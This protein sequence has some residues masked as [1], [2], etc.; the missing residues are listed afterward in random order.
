[1]AWTTPTAAQLRARLAGAE[2]TALASFLTSGDSAPLAAILVEATGT[3]RGYIAANKGN[4]LGAGDTVPAVLL[5]TTLVLARH[6]LLN[7]LPSSSLLT[8]GRRNEHAD[9]LRRL[10]HVAA[11]KFA[12][13]QPETATTETT[14]PQPGPRFAADSRRFT[15]GHQDGL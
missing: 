8:E 10:Q 5:D 9:A 14:T 12:V 15:R 7:R 1:M 6:A 4:T 13:E 2:V 3:V 11:G